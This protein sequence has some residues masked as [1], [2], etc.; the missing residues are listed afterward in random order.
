MLKENG[1][2]PTNAQASTNRR[3]LPDGYTEVIAKRSN[4][5]V[6]SVAGHSDTLCAFA[7][8]HYASMTGL[9]SRWI[10]N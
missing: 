7:E 4:G 9:D 6:G 5:V 2:V 10:Q 1:L 3:A 8:A